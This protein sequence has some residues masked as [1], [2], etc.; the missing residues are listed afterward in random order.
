MP[1]CKICTGWGS[2]IGVQGELAVMSP[3]SEPEATKA[4]VGR[5]LR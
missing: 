1:V 3:M 5:K 4:S 2:G